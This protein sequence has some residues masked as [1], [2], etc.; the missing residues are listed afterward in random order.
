M[1]CNAAAASIS[2]NFEGVMLCPGEELI[3][4]C[5]GQGPV[6]RW[7]VTDEDGADIEVTFISTQS[8]E[9]RL[10]SH[11][12]NTMTFE[13][14]LTSVAFDRFE[15]MVSVVVTEEINSTRVECHGRFSGDSVV[16]MITGWYKCSL[17]CLLIKN[18]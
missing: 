9:R 8:D 14:S 18:V 13:F 10:I 7:T 16:L 6:Q 17:Q 3:L 5:T 1:R 15:S 2:S 12:F 11:I 4:T